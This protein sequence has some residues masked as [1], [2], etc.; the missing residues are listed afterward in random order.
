MRYT[1]LQT[2]PRNTAATPFFVTCSLEA[3][4]DLLL[5]HR[6]ALLVAAVA[7]ALLAIVLKTQQHEPGIE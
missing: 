4:H 1:A 6:I 2:A 3:R 5:D 7:F